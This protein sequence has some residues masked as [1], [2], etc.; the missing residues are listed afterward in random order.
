MRPG[1]AFDSLVERHGGHVLLAIGVV[2][3]GVA[4]AGYQRVLPAPFSAPQ[5]PPRCLGCEQ[6]TS[7]SRSLVTIGIFCIGA[8]IRALPYNRRNREAT[9]P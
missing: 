6:L 9:R 2:A 1:D 4:A 7:L 3:L 8:G 5:F